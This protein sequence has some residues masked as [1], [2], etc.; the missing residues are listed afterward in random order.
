MNSIYK[1]EIKKNHKDE[2]IRLQ[3]LCKVYNM[4][5]EKVSAV[6][7]VNFDIKK[8]EFVAIVGPSG[9]G[10]STMMNMV[11]ALDLATK[12][13]IYLDGMDIEHISESNLAQIRGK[14]IGFIFQ[15]FNLIPTLN[16]LENVELP[17]IFQGISKYKRRERA[18]KLLEEVKL[19]H[20]LYHLPSELSGGE[21]QRVAIARALAND[22]EVILADE[23]TGNLD[24]KT[25]EEILKM[26]MELNKQGKTIVMITHDNLLAS[27]ARR[28]IRLKDGQVV[29]I[30]T[31]K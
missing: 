28:I 15:T 23:P 10:K 16:A 13:D 5:S 3:D 9:S 24:S 6:C 27:K 11:G 22:P 19:S 30:E 2:I 21:R 17:M 31:K 26:F 20:R 29:G 8:G 14:K 25:G 4:G 7:D 12:G 1:M 18:K